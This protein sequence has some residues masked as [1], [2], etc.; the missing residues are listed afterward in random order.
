[1]QLTAHNLN[2]PEAN[3]TVKYLSKIGSGKTASYVICVPVQK[4]PAVPR[5]RH[6]GSFYAASFRKK[7][8]RFRKKH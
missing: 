7:P 6:T 3:E 5:T 8:L 1:M 4:Y 2:E